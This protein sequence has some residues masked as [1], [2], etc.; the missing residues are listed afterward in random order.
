MSIHKKKHISG[1]SE[2]SKN[3]KFRIVGGREA[4]RGEFPHQVSLQ[5]YSRHFCGGAI[6]SERWVLTAAH[7][8]SRG[9]ITVMA[10]KH[11]IH[12]SEDTEQNVEVDDVYVHEQFSGY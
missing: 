9:S 3:P 8:V 4:S 7:C 6:I 5:V 12:E 10:G 1:V 2:D 11:N